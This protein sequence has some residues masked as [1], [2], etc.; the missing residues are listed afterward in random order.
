M[1]IG[2]IENGLKRPLHSKITHTAKKVL[3]KG[4][5]GLRWIPGQ[6]HFNPGTIYIYFFDISIFNKK[7]I[8]LFSVLAGSVSSGE[9]SR[10]LLIHSPDIPRRID[11]GPK[12][13]NLRRYW[14][15]YYVDSS[16]MGGSTST[17]STASEDGEAVATMDDRKVK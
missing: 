1:L 10:D 17:S 3:K 6:V 13:A 2:N 5:Q 4:F 16:R 15:D 7:K 14:R 8:Y 11:C 9:N 12:I